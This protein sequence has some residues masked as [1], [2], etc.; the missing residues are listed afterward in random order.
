MTTV[1]LAYDDCHFQLENLV[2]FFESSS[3]NADSYFVFSSSPC[4]LL[5]VDDIARCRRVFGKMDIPIQVN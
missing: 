1:D 4:V 3:G 5:T 2:P